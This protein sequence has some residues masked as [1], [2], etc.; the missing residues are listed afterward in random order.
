[1]S[2]MIKSENVKTKIIPKILVT[3]NSLNKFEKTQ[4]AKPPLTLT[5]TCFRLKQK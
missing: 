4:G 1:M 5:P 3:K 2:K